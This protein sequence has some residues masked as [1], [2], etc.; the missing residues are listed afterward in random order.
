MFLPMVFCLFTFSETLSDMQQRVEALT[1]IPVAEQIVSHE[2]RVV[3]E[4]GHALV[5]RMFFFFCSCLRFFLS[6]SF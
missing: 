2:G 6:P 5:D 3:E 1:G 4:D